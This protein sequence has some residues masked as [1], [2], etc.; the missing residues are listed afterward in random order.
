MKEVK[1]IE[2]LQEGKNR[3]NPNQNRVYDKNG[4][5]PTLNCM[6]GGDYSHILLKHLNV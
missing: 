1:Q 3:K 2:N 5:S 4:I 6:Q